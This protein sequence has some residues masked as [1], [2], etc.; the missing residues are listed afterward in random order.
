MIVE[1]FH[2]AKRPEPYSSL[3]R[4]DNGALYWVPELELGVG[5]TAL[6]ANVGR[7]NAPFIFAPLA[8]M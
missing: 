5:F 7:N 4:L 3:V 2:R 6:S 1:I 8:M